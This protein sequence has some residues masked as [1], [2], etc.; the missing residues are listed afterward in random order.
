[1][2]GWEDRQTD[3]RTDGCVAEILLVFTQFHNATKEPK[4]SG[5]DFTW[6]FNPFLGKQSLYVAAVLLPP[7]RGGAGKE[8]P[9]SPPAVSPPGGARLW[10][11]C[12]RVGPRCPARV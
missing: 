11:P 10:G 4:S 9:R 7:K 8:T 1:M 6:I 2:D 5:G 12:P 3:G